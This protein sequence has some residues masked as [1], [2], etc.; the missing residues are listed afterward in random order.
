MI[1]RSAGETSGGRTLKAPPIRVLQKW[2]RN[3][4]FERIE[5][6]GL[7]ARDF[8]LTDSK[9]EARIKHKWSKSYFSL[10]RP[11][12]Q[13]VAERVVGDGPVWPT[14]ATSWHS[15]MERVSTWLEEVKRDFETPDLW[16]ELQREN[17]LLRAG[18]N[19]LTENA[20]FTPD[21]QKEIARRLREL[22]K[23]VKQ[24][25][26]FSET[27]TQLLEQ[28]S[29][30]SLTLRVGLVGRIGSTR[31]LERPLVSS[32]GR[33]FRQNLRVPSFR[34]SFGGSVCSTPS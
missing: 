11:P 33:R 6:V 16:A 12:S 8:K 9:G 5:A 22:A 10:S 29:T 3:D 21:E 13:Y 14:S 18:S 15:L 26:A 27:K 1:G 25:Y 28:S 20:L 2:Q 19:E 30:T 4:I 24:T 17:K 7:H 23:S 34:R 31:L 32:S